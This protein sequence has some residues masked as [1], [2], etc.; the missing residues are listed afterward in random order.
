MHA[1][2]YTKPI[3]FYLDLAQNMNPIQLSDLDGQAQD[4]RQH[5]GICPL[6]LPHSIF[7]QVPKNQWK[8]LN[9]IRILVSFNSFG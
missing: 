5:G 6:L 7:Y 2:Y 1:S 3:E 9:N 4:E 8:Y